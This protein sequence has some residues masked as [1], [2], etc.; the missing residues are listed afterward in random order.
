MVCDLFE[1]KWIYACLLS[2][3]YL[4]TVVWEQ[5][6]N[7][8]RVGIPLTGLTPPHFYAS[9]KPG[10][11]FL[12]S[13]VVVFFVFSELMWEIS[14]CFVDNGKIVFLPSFSKRLYK[15][16]IYVNMSTC[17]KCHMMTISQR[18]WYSHDVLPRQNI[19]L[20]RYQDGIV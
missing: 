11:G 2:F 5:V 10:P 9:P 7:M 1:C 20:C 18:C 12:T 6:I 15:N 13:Y 3:V 16:D 19:I 17:Y 14:V 4:C 8:E